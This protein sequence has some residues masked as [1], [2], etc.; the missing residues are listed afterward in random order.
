MSDERREKEE[1][2]RAF[3]VHGKA[4]HSHIAN[5]LPTESCLAERCSELGKAK[6]PWNARNGKG[7]EIGKEDTRAREGKD[8]STLERS[9]QPIAA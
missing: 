9:G 2:Q 3:C 1:Q 7:K 6:L 5:G 8:V 4:K